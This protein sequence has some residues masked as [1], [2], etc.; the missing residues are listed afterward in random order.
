MI[1]S[2]KRTF[3]NRSLERA[4]KILCSF[5]LENREWS[6]SELSQSL[7]LPKSTVFRLC[8]TLSQHDFLRYTH[9]TK[10]Y[11]LGIKLFDLGSVV[12][13][14]ISVR[15]AAS[16]HLTRLQR[17]TEK[18]VFLGVLQDD[19]LL[20]MD[21]RDAPKSPIRFTT[22]IGTRRQPYFGVLGQTLLAYLPKKEVLRILKD[23]PLQ[24]LT[25]T[26]LTT[27]KALM[28]RLQRVRRQG[29]AI[30]SGEV[31]EGVGGIAAPIRDFSGQV[32]AAIGV[33][34]I[35]ASEGKRKKEKL[36]GSVRDAAH[37]I[38]LDLGYKG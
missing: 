25:K 30:D 18:T 3:F 38:S 36:I 4:L 29:H 7:D 21:K 1:K 2:A 32:V 27:K 34:F 37:K 15:K 24:P 19:Q 9:A 11:R 20:Y 10:K 14:S 28:E 16:N 12:F 33:R 22:E 5:T 35:S 13:A 6:L 8:S 26:S 31:I 23:N 17:E